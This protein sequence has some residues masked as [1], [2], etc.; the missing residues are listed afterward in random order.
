MA[1]RTAA[2]QTLKEIE[3][4]VL[5]PV[6]LLF[7]PEAYYIDRITRSLRQRVVAP[8]SLDFDDE[9]IDGDSASMEQVFSR[10]ASPP[11]FGERRL[12]VV[13]RTPWFKGAS[14][15]GHSSLER[16]LSAPLAS[17]VLVLQ[18]GNE[19]DRRK[20]AFKLVEKNGLV[21]E[22]RELNERERREWI[23]RRA[24]ELGLRLEAEALQHLL[25]FGG[26][27]LYGLEHEL[28]K[29]ADYYGSRGGEVDI[30]A[31]KEVCALHAEDRLFDIMEAVME[32]RTSLALARTREVLG[33]GIPASKI[34]YLLVRDYR[35]LGQIQLGWELGLS[36]SEL[37]SRL[38]AQFKLPPFLVP[39]YLRSA[40]R[41]GRG[42]LKQGLR[43]MLTL[44]VDVKTGRETPER[45]LQLLIAAISRL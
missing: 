3:R 38:A 10:A 8:E 14:E 7:G 17:T 33:A 44:D 35:I 18:A 27:S 45:A 28:Q 37:S 9:T 4:G 34:F 21:V 20:K 2:E 36:D 16:Y 6:Y 22:C 43:V 29:L 39:R 26:K 11:W 1:H 23:G 41:L 19:V 15:E 13:K 25:L 42:A 5:R 24:R 12:V 40:G 32:G 30:R 31:V